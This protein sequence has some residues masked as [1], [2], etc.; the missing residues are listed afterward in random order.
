MY[1]FFLLNFL[2]LVF[3]PIAHLKDVSFFK[4]KKDFLI[5]LG[6]RSDR[7]RGGGLRGRSKAPRK[8]DL[9]S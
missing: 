2:N 9:T 1:F 3:I 6:G 5:F 4:K 7:Y 8:D